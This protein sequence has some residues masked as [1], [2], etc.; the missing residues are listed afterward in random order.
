MVLCF[1]VGIVFGFSFS[2]AHSKKK[3]L[4]IQESRQEQLQ[5]LQSKY[6]D[7]VKSYE[8]KLISSKEANVMSTRTVYM[9]S[10]ERIVT[11]VVDR[12]IVKEQEKNRTTEEVGNYEKS[13]SRFSLGENL[14]EKKSSSSPVSLS[15][16][17]VSIMGFQDLNI[18]NMTD[19]QIYGAIRLFNLPIWIDVG[20]TPS[21]VIK[22]PQA[23]FG[24]EL[25]F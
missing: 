1:I 13:N 9:P 4:S 25:E 24:I 3:E 7:M 21:Q 22:S 2:L 12:S 5:V 10:G 19:V 20:F 6:S 17:K 23:N 18:K 14:V 11:K 16:Y 8:N 15:H